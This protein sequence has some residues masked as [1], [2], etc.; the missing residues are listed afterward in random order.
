MGR[1]QAYK[2][3]LRKPF[4]QQLITQWWVSSLCCERNIEPGQ[5]ESGVRDSSLWEEVRSDACN[6]IGQTCAF[7]YLSAR[8]RNQPS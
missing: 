8:D 1:L 3:L 4:E 2:D 7:A 6:R 5:L